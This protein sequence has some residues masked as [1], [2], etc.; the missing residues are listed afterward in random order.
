MDYP[1]L[2]GASY[3]LAHAPD[4]VVYGSKPWREVNRDPDLKGPLL[5]GLRS[6]EEAVRYPPNQVFIGNL[7]PNKLRAIPS[8]WYGH[9]ASELTPRGPFGRIIPEQDLYEM[10]EK[11]D[12][13]HLVAFADGM[14]PQSLPSGALPLYGGENQKV[15]GSIR[16]DHPEDES[17]QARILLENLL[18]KA[19]ATLAL[20][21]LLQ[22]TGVS[23]EDIDYVISCS[24]EA[25]GDR[26]NRGGGNLGKAIAEAA[27]CKNASGCDIKAFCA[28]PIHAII[29]AASLVAASVHR[30]VAVVAGGSLAKL[31]MKF[32][33]HLQKG[34]PVLEDMLG[35][36]AFLIGNGDGKNPQLRLDA[37]ASAPVVSSLS[38][39]AL[40]ESLIAN[41]L[42]KVGLRMSDIDRFAGELH[43][44]EITVPSGSG[45]V[46]LV[47]YRSMAALAVLRGEI[48]REEISDF[49]ETR[50]LPGYA[51]TQGHIPAGVPYLGHALEE[52]R[53]G[54]MRRAFFL[55]KGS[56]F[57]G[58]M[59]GLFDGASFLLE[60]ARI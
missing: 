28:A 16:S 3:L 56:L 57:L 34:I 51:P 14:D 35:G 46:A 55:A 48:K 58:R 44:P 10:L 18:A 11:A 33:S 6:W 31:G 30:R 43:N 9:L 21:D 2:K 27:G 13:L 5:N 60:A 59:T 52:M 23:P 8:P 39:Q 37:S 22:L 53:K 1:A 24:E 38:Q 19:T 41:P 50:G 32:T 29:H 7:S 47:N 25:I 15:I 49:V 17:L 54:E 40:L 45:D 20:T 4:L 42:E 26:Y 36:M 12:S